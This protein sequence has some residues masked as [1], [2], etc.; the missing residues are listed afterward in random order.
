M[1]ALLF[2]AEFLVLSLREEG[3][4]TTPNR[5]LRSLDLQPAHYNSNVISKLLVNLLKM[6]SLGMRKAVFIFWSAMF[7]AVFILARQAEV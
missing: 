3:F 1:G 4:S 5:V 2:Y 6:G 7:A